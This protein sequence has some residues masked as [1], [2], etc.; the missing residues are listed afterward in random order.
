MKFLCRLSD[1]VG[2][3]NGEW[4]DGTMTDIGKKYE[5]GLEELI[6]RYAED[7]RIES[8]SY[9][10]MG[11]L[12]EIEKVKKRLKTYGIHE[13]YIYG[14]GYL[15]VQLFNAVNAFADVKAVVD[16]SGSLS[17]DVPGIRSISIKDLEKQYTNEKII[18]TPVRYYATV[19][20]DLIRFID[21]ENILY[22]GEFLEGVI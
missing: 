9:K 16:K 10:M 12:L 18:I 8:F 5:E 19:R 2:K 7:Y 14:G 3:H 20:Q 15:G 6:D 21:G 13:L 1:A 22:L 4:K 11:K 17:V